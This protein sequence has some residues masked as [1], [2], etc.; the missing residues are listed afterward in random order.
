MKK[1]ILFLL[2]VLLFAMA[3]NA[4][5]FTVNSFDAD[6]ADLSARTNPVNDLNG[7]KC[8]L[9]RVSLPQDGGKFLG[10]VLI[11]KYVINEYQ[12][13]V[14]QGTRDLQFMYPGMETLKLDLR[15]YT[16]G[17]GVESGVTY[18]L[19]LSGFEDVVSRPQQNT[20]KGNYLI[21]DITPKKGVMVEVDGQLQQ[22]EDGQASV[23][24]D[25]GSHD[26]SVKAPGFATHLETVGIV[27][28]GKTV[29]NIRLESIQ[30]HLT[31]KSSMSGAIIKINGRD[32]GRGSFSDVVAP[33]SYLIEVENDGYRSYS[34]TVE[35]QQKENRT[36]N[37]P[38][39][40]P[41][42]GNLDVAY[43]PMG[44]NIAIDG[45]I[46][47]TT[48][49]VFRDIIVGQYTIT[50]S[51][52]GYETATI[53]TK[54]TEDQP[55]RLT[56]Q[57]RPKA[58][59]PSGS[60]NS[61]SNLSSTNLNGYEAIDLGLSVKWASCNIG[62]FKATDYGN[63][64]AWGETVPKPNYTAEN[65]ILYGVETGDIGGSQKDIAHTKWEGSWRMPTKNE[66]EELKER[67]KWEWV[68]EDG[69]HGYRITAPNGNS[70][71]LPAAGYRSD[72]S[73]IGDGEDGLYWSSTPASRTDIAWSLNFNSDYYNVDWGGR[74]GG[75]PVRPVTK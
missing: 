7:V 39:L 34:E 68:M 12:V 46:I 5:E 19:R 65:C 42:Y 2:P 43:T 1:C 49:E 15:P 24:L 32:R 72:K 16:D 22:V 6:P 59:Q 21:L 54:L 14:S 37:I 57:L 60:D 69:H 58:F 18:T 67:C 50:I 74:H 35:L 75:F 44:A 10:N 38:D 36:V 61:S 29:K 70:I 51:K 30:A 28:E 4:R 31:V 23:F 40:Q 13:Y 3:L 11:Q 52:D 26:L 62:A 27:P 47:G 48:P 73:I 55:T 56:G 20:I 8:A 45:I 25:F 71:F 53:Y 66:W 41:I 63:Y 33:G 17:K 9:I 64:F